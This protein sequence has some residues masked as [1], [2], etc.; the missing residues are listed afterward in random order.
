VSGYLF[1][2]RSDAPGDPARDE[3]VVQTHAWVEIA[4]PRAGWWALDPTNRL[5]VG[6]RH[7]KIGHGRD[8]GD[9]LP[10]RGLYHGPFQHELE[11]EVRMK[12]L[13]PGP[14][15]S[16]PALSQSSLAR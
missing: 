13:T 6:T 7:V 12:R 3:V 15:W 5:T 14:G 11:V 2:P 8:Y 16:E 1:A 4:L 10:L 9:V